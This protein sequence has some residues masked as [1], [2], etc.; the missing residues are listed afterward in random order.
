M[1]GDTGLCSHLPYIHCPLWWLFQSISLALPAA[2]LP[3]SALLGLS[4]CL[5]LG[6]DLAHSQCC[7]FLITDCLFDDFQDLNK[8]FI[9][10][11]VYIQGQEWQKMS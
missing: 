1:V 4:D 10:A 8:K 2:L 6:V 5:H 9:R 11:G 3:A 7:V